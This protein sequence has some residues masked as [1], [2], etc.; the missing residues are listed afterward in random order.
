MVRECSFAVLLC[1]SCRL[2][3]AQAQFELLVG[4]RQA[5]QAHSAQEL[6]DYLEILDAPSDRERVRLVEAFAQHHPHSELLGIAYQYQMLAYR[7]LNDYDGVV[8]SGERALKLH[9]DN[10]NTLLI[11]ANT[12]P[13]RV[14]TGTVDDPRLAQAEQ[15]VRL[16]FEGIERMKLPR[17]VSPQR[18]Q[19]LR[20]EME[21]SAHE[22]LGHVATKRGKLQEAILE[23]ERAVQQNP[24]P[25]GSQFYRLGVAYM[26][27]QKND[28]AREALSRAA[29]LGPDGIRKMA[30]M[31][32]Q[33]LSTKPH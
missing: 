12:L 25:Q 7:G 28:S 4:P 21:A 26:L 5:P 17:S 30:N 3:V 6:D 10:L 19:E 24:V 16:V 31:A 18:W 8:Q 15:Y 22:A 14:A 27:A 9:P 1:L 20:L 33:K 11:L 13:N 32:M 29:E 2:P 23:F